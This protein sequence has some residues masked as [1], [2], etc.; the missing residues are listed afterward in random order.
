MKNLILPRISTRG[1]YDL[2]T[3][4]TLKKNS[5]FLYPKQSF[6]KL[7]G[8]SDL[9][10][11][12][13]G[14]RNDRAGA[15]E[16][17]KIAKSRLR[18][19]GYKGHVIGFSYDSNTKGAHLKKYE[20]RSL[21]AGQIIAQK[22]GKNLSKFLIDFKSKSPDTKIRLMG[23]SLGS[24]VI[25]STTEQLFAKSKNSGV[26]ESVYFFGAS[27]KNTV[28]SS[29]KYVKKLD[30]VIKSKIVNYFA[31]T[32]EVLKYAHEYGLVKNPL[33]LVGSSNKT[34]IKYHQK[35]VNPKNHRFASYAKVISSFP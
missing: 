24:Q 35:K 25:L 34:M 10:I 7:I 2:T 19:L 6:E 13:H 28:P 20:K 5:Y 9:T 3:G 33:G 16:K 4:K 27:I 32:D 26:I 30:R 21:R 1:F 29:K 8:C 17:I 31:P 23:H 15:V 11:M 14:L 18:K 12:I 22:N